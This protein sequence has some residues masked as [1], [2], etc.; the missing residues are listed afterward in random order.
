MPTGLANVEVT[1]VPGAASFGVRYI[2]SYCWG[3]R[4]MTCW[5]G[6]PPMWVGGLCFSMPDSL[7]WLAMLLGSVLRRSCGGER[8]ETGPGLVSSWVMRGEVRGR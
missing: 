4:E 7:E 5:I 6:V 2:D 1:A 3:V 8:W